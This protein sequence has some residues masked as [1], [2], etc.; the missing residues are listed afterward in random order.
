MH[1]RRRRSER[2]APLTLGTLRP[3]PSDRDPSR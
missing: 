1:T 2:R 3:A